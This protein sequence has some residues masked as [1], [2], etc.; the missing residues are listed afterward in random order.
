MSFWSEVNDIGI[1]AYPPLTDKLD[2]SVDQMVHAWK[3]VPDDP[4]WAAAMD[5]MS[6]VDFFHSLAT[7]HHKQVVFT[8]VGYRSVDG[9]N[10]NPGNASGNTPDA[11][12]QAQAFDAFFQVWGSEGG[13]WFKGAE[14]WQWDAHNVF[15]PTGYSPMDKP[16]QSLITEWF[17]GQHQAPA[18]TIDGSPSAD[19]VDIGSG[20]DRVSG[21]LGNDAI[22]AGAGNDVVRGGPD[23]LT[24]LADTTVT[25][26]GFGSVVDG[27][28]PKMQLSV[29]GQ[30]VGSTVEFH[31][32]A[33][34]TGYQTYTF[35]LQ[36]PESVSSLD[37]SFTNDVAN[38]HGDRNLYVE[39]IAVNGEKLAAEDATN[40]SSPGT[41]DLYRNNSIHYDMSRHQNL[42]FG[43][44]SDNDQINGGR[45]NDYLIGGAGND[46]FT[47]RPDF[48]NDVISGFQDTSSAQD[49]LRF[50][51][52]VFA[53][54]QAVASHMAQVG[55]SVVIT[56]DAHNTIEIQNTTLAHLKADDFHFL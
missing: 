11:H 56:Y 20:N 18:L 26:T 8:E 47:F 14:I 25:V 52:N 45:G 19:F 6:P 24:K 4:Y 21:G 48:G 29:N 35:N 3:S 33:D 51:H 54:F 16:A 30:Q 43:A 41:W 23:T 50:D 2:P 12:E 32:A 31:Q 40:P 55:D 28:G 22:I 42:F 17:N 36:N 37:L 5:H 10:I 44:G 9:T 49:V 46:T 13:S 27:E 1:N 53:D 39:G 34:S 7:E 15:S 38:A